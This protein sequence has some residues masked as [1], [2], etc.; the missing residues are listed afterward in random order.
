MNQDTSLTSKFGS[1]FF[2]PEL[3]DTLPVA[4]YTCDRLGYI[5]SY[6]K[7]AVAL[8]GR[9]PE[10]KKDLWC[11][12]WK[13]FGEDGSPMPLDTCPMAM[14]LK[15]NRPI[16]GAKIV[17]Q[18]P[19]GAKRN[20]IPHPVPL[21][22]NEGNLTGAINTLIDITD[23]VKS[24]AQIQKLLD[25]TRLLDARKDEFIGLASHEL[26]T[27]VTTIGAYL[28]LIART[29]SP[30]DSTKTLISKAQYQLAKLNTL[31]ADLLDI[32][33]LQT[34]SL[35]LS[36]NDFNLIVLVKEVIEMMRRINPS[37]ELTLY[38]DRDE[39]SVT[40]DQKRMEQVITNL[41]SNATKYS[42]QANHV[43]I[44]ISAV[45]DVANVSVQDFG[46]G[47]EVEEQGRIFHRFYRAN[48]SNS[49]ISGLGIGLYMCNEII[50]RHQGRL[51]VES[52][53]G[54]GSTFFFEI[55]CSVHR[56]N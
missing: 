5:T 2:P 6:N 41:I 24:N 7:A 48:K 38:S 37:H 40:G 8:W 42:Y 26:K 50:L 32:T 27:P 36:T 1:E 35:D 47:I 52:T 19:D 29:F 31:I 53:P 54:S 22:D 3:F 56:L 12:S 51:W 10:L 14:A 20:I 43:V 28:Q 45:Q 55:P 30:E 34:G 4:I 46:I 15:E 18:C 44:R 49:H 16:T 33:E 23:Q 39:L 13:I 17:V 11:G 9:E 21:Y 25:E